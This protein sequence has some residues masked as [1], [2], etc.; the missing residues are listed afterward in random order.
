MGN[1]K[2][3]KETPRKGKKNFL[4]E[5]IKARKKQEPP[6]QLATLLYRIKMITTCK[7]IGKKTDH[8]NFESLAFI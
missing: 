1:L 6:I 2:N 3:K 5:N 4:I 7:S 8:K